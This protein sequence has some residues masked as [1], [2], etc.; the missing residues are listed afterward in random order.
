MRAERSEN[1]RTTSLRSGSLRRG[2]SRALTLPPLNSA[3]NQF[4]RILQVQFFLDVFAMR[5]DRLDAD[6]KLFRN[7]PTAQALPD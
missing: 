1:K 3:L 4:S 2:L 7:L 5:F 6:A